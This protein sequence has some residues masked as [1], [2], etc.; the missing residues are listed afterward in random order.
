MRLKRLYRGIF[1]KDSRWWYASIA[2]IVLTGV[3]VSYFFWESLHNDQYSFS[4]T[5]SNL[6]LV[7]GGTVAIVLA[8]WRSKVSERQTDVAQRQAETA[9]RDLLNQQLQKGAEL[10]GSSVLAV[11]LG[12]IYTL[13]NLALEHPEQYHI[14]V[15]EQLCAFVRGTTGADG[16]VSPARD[17]WM[18]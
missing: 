15:M 18:V 11:R 16:Q 10:L 4:T 8:V 3:V 17:L 14:Q 7:L 9:Q 2:V 1:K 6:S 13:R 12:G 5:I